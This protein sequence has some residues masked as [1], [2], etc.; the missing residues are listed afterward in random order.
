MAQLV[1]WFQQQS[2]I[3]GLALPSNS[4]DKQGQHELRIKM[5]VPALFHLCFQ[6]VLSEA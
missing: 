4:G 2:Q 5:L 1:F 6:K 3:F